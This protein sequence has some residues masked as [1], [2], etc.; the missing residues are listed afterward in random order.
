MVLSKPDN[1]KVLSAFSLRGKVAAVTGGARGIGLEVSRGLAEAGADVAI[2]YRTSKDAPEIAA[3]IAKANGVKC[4]TYQAEVKDQKSIED[5]LIQIA[6][7]F[8]KLDV[9]VANAGI[10]SHYAAEDVT[11]EQWSEIMKVN[12]DGAFWTAQAAGRIFKQQGQGNLIFTA[13]VSA[14]L[15][16]VPQKQAAY[17]ASKAGLVQLARCLAVE[18]VDFC[19]VNC[20]SPGFIATDMLSVHPEEWRKKWFGMI[21]AQR[22]CD[23]YELKGAYVF[24]ASNASSY[25]TGANMVIDGAY[26]LP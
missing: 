4:A 6:K 22:L 15:V 17:N 19:R 24:L 14:I 10:A 7:D 21:P 23:P 18:W 11:V 12:L 26:T 8:G 1:Q 20:V 16:N 5:T 13:S 2:I 3:E 9:V 25:M